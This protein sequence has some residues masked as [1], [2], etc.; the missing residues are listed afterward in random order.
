M[1]AHKWQYLYNAGGGI[2]HVTVLESN[3]KQKM[4]GTRYFRVTIMGKGFKQTFTSVCSKVCFRSE[5]APDLLMFIACQ[6]LER[7]SRSDTTKNHQIRV[8]KENW[9]LIFF[10]EQSTLCP[11]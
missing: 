8:F 6:G 5:T 11:L 10:I 4:S 2:R 9:Q 1:G 7:C 3:T